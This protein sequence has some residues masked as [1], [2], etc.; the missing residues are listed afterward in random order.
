MAIRFDVI[1]SA[2]GGLASQVTRSHQITAVH[3]SPPAFE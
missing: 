3:P 2:L 1:R